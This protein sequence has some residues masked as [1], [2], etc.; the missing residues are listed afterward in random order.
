MDNVITD[1]DLLQQEAKKESSIDFKMVTFSLAGKDYGID[2]MTV[3]EISKAGKFTFVPNSAPYV[4]GVYNLRGDIISVIDLRIFFNQPAKQSGENE[5]ESMIIVRLEDHVIGII[6]DEIDKVVGISS[7][8]VQPPHPLFG[9]INIKYISGVAENNNRL[10]V[11]LDVEAIFGT[12]NDE[13][14]T[15]PAMESSSGR[16]AAAPAESQ[17]VQQASEPV[18]Q[19]ERELG[20]I[21]E[22]LITFKQFYASP[23]NDD[24]IRRRYSQWFEDRYN[25]NKSIQLTGVDDADSYLTSFY[26]PY[27]E[28]LWSEEYI[29][30]VTAFIP[31]T[32]G[33]N[34][35]VWNP[36]C[37]KGYETY[38]VL[39]MLK[40]Y[41]SDLNIKIHGSD[42]DLISVASAPGLLFQ[43]NSVPDFYQEFMVESNSGLQFQ[44]SM[45]DLIMFEFRDLENLEVFSRLDMVIIRD[46]LSF[47][48]VELQNK[49]IQVILDNLKDNGVLI[50][51]QNE[52]LPN[53][54]GWEDIS[55]NGISAYRKK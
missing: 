39:S 19:S 49:V 37:G 47:L 18:D 17:S 32:S 7:E 9:D 14:D 21:K 5:L 1:I 23:V 26:S 24:W 54:S 34:F 50:L 16:F 20:F 35:N 3:K 31:Q 11:I 15:V 8:S 33:V 44:N 51:G 41:K 45:K 55:A 53:L 36:G 10:Y 27:T 4:R 12:K 46:V 52:R 43:K 29:H 38:S 2:I 22:T 25:S 48:K 28:S 30:A 6:V 42:K 13:D 40:K